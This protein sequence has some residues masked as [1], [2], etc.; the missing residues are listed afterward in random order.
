[1]L[2]VDNRLHAS[3]KLNCLK[4]RLTRFNN[5]KYCRFISAFIVSSSFDQSNGIM[6]RVM[7]L[8]LGKKEFPS[9]EMGDSFLNQLSSFACDPR[10]ACC[11][12]KRHNPLQSVQALPA[13][14]PSSAGHA[15]A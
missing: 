2:N 4:D 13:S 8:K 9:Q 3:W 1:M 11:L 15:G 7:D 12:E 6:N 5:G 14:Q 10:Q